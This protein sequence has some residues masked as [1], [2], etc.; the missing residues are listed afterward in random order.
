MKDRRLTIRKTADIRTG[1]PQVILWDQATEEDLSPNYN[2]PMM[3]ELGAMI[4]L[5]CLSLFT[6]WVFSGTRAR[7]LL[8]RWVRICDQNH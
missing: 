4:D 7:A 2:A 3:G 6:G 8:A 5:T 1:P